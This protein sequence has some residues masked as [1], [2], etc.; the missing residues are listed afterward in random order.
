MV[1]TDQNRIQLQRSYVTVTEE[2]G[3]V[4]H[5]G[6]QSWLSSEVARSYGCGLIAAADILRYLRKDTGE[7]LTKEEYLAN[8]ETVQK[9]FPVKSSL[10]ITGFGL[11]RRMNRMFRREGLPFRARWGMSGRKLERRIREMLQADIPVLLSVGPCFRHKSERLPLY[12]RKDGKDY[13]RSSG[14]KDH[15]VTVTGWETLDTAGRGAPDTADGSAP[16]TA[17]RD[18]SESSGVGMM[19]ISSWGEKYYVNFNEYREF[20][21]KNDNFLFSNILYIRRKSV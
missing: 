1:V 7:A 19:E 10:G 12:R 5:G 17:G 2:Q 11:S 20:V 21:R 4:T 9:D 14:M 18:V 8:I 6:D 3:R 15:Y 16:D 13:E